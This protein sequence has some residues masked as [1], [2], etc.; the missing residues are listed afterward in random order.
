MRFFISLLSC[1]FLLSGGIPSASAA[2][3]DHYVRVNQ[4][5]VQRDRNTVPVGSEIPVKYDDG[6]SWV[7]YRTYV[8]PRVPK[9]VGTLV[10]QK[11]FDP[12]IDGTVTQLTAIY[13]RAT[14][15]NSIATKVIPNTSGTVLAKGE[16]VKIGVREGDFYWVVASG[17]RALL[18]VGVV[19]VSPAAFATGKVTGVPPVPPP[20]AQPV[21][22]TPP[23]AGRQGQLFGKLKVPFTFGGKVLGTGNYIHV[24]YD[25]G[26]YWI[27]GDL[28]LEGGTRISKAAVDLVERVEFNPLLIGRISS[29]TPVYQT[30]PDLN[31]NPQTLR[32]G[33]M[34]ANLNPTVQVGDDVNILAREG[35]DYIAQIQPRGR[36][37]QNARIP[38]AAVSITSGNMNAGAAV[39]IPPRPQ[40]ID[41]TKPAFFKTQ[42]MQDEESRADFMWKCFAV[43]LVTLVVI[44]V[45]LVVR[46]F[47]VNMAPEVN[48]DPNKWW[49]SSETGEFSRI[50]TD[51]TEGVLVDSR[52][53]S[54][55]LTERIR[56]LVI[57]A[58]IRNAAVVF[59]VVGAAVY[60]YQ[61]VYTNLLMPFV[62][63]FAVLEAA[64]WLQQFGLLALSKK[65]TLPPT[66]RTPRHLDEYDPGDAHQPT[67][68]EMARALRER[69]GRTAEEGGVDTEPRFEA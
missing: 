1:I 8:L 15:G 43:L 48:I 67:P 63:F 14:V 55:I 12:P 53:Y 4:Q 5:L 57:L 34:F 33:Q 26:A 6:D 39:T 19:S 24:T 27:I 62:A 31:R 50:T 44:P 68:D 42:E 52:P 25:D 49:F 37:A 21:A 32:Q 38:V 22:A 61:N 35:D 58:R 30:F 47:R 9:S 54:Q 23:K 59:G 20:T 69:Q 56:Q 10:E 40:H 18:P 3:I 65:F 64:V 41:S 16:P 46:R 45:D 13:Q 17:Y 11:I 51:N 7:T 66:P 2:D 28:T 29:P 60:Y 36:P